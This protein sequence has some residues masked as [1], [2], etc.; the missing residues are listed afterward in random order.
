MGCQGVED[1]R[2][3]AKVCDQCVMVVGNCGRVSGGVMDW[4]LT[5][6]QAGHW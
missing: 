2:N 6:L 3:A 5:E 4:V 1:F